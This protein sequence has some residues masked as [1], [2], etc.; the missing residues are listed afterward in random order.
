M[1]N[2]HSLGIAILRPKYTVKGNFVPILSSMS[3]WLRN[4]PL[5][6]KRSY[7]NSMLLINIVGL[8]GTVILLFP[9]TG[10]YSTG[11]SLV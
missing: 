8:K 5:L 2:F 11:M 4:S 10:V 3:F 1:Y 7:I 6:E 9:Q